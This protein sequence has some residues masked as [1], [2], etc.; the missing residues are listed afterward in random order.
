MNE[1]TCDK[2]GNKISI[3]K[4]LAGQI[5]AQVF[6]AEHK[7]HEAELAEVKKKAADFANEQL[8]QRLELE[9]EKTKQSLELEREKMKV[10]LEG[11]T[12]KQL[13]QQELLVQQLREDAKSEKEAATEL[14]GQLKGVTTRREE[15]T[16]RCRTYRPEE[17]S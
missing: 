9:A 8:K 13:Q 10:E 5:E 2:C 1:V 3:D 12:K 17:A 6:A 4:A 14:R 11:Q 7:K 15:S 16:G